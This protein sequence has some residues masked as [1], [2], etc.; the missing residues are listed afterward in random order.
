MDGGG[1]CHASHASMM[2][3]AIEKLENMMRFHCVLMDKKAI[4]HLFPRHT[5][6]HL[7]KTKQ[8]SITNIQHLSKIFK[9]RASCRPAHFALSHIIGHSLPR[10]IRSVILVR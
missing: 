7:S 9:L 4:L 3:H 2:S 8:R 6:N 5:V 10:T 1:P